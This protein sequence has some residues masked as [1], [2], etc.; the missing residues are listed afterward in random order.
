VTVGR[1]DFA[2]LF[3]SRDV[4]VVQA[5]QYLLAELHAYKNY[6]S[7]ENTRNVSQL[8]SLTSLFSTNIATLETKGR[9]ESYP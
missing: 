6:L 9:V 5:W 8:G 1:Q 4:F 2:I 3:L 7:V